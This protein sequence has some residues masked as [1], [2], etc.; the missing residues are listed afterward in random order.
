MFPN[1]DFELYDNVGRTTEQINAYNENR[2]TGDD[3]RR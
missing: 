3:L 1:P 2:P